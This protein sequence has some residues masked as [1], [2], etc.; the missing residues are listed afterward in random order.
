[1]MQYNKQK[2]IMATCA[3]PPA[4]AAEA[5]AKRAA[6]AWLATTSVLNIKTPDNCGGAAVRTP[7]WWPATLW[8]H[9]LLPIPAAISPE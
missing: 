7:S 4:T 8:P 5:E 3:R 2:P 6:A 1:M 9:L